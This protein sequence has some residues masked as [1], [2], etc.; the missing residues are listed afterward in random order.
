[1]VMSLKHWTT[2]C[3]VSDRVAP[4]ITILNEKDSAVQ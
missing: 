3:H 4:D 1:M 2:L